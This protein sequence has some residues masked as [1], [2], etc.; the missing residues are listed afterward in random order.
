MS[1]VNLF[2]QKPEYFIIQSEMI[3]KHCKSRRINFTSCNTI[4]ETQVK[5]KELVCR[6]Q[7][8]GELKKL[9][10]GNIGSLQKLDIPGVLG[11]ISNLEI[12][13]PAGFKA[14][15]AETDTTFLQTNY[16]KWVEKLQE[17]IM[18]DIYITGAQAVTLKGEIFSSDNVGNQICGIIFGPRK[19]IIIVGKNSIYENL[20]T[21]LKKNRSLS[22]VIVYGAMEG[23]KDR[24]HLILVNEELKPMDDLI[25]A[26]NNSG[27]LCR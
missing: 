11:K 9:G 25:K 12:I 19:V 4:K 23:Y 14:N 1:N 18:S 15:I 24:I 26:D 6:S 7:N 21:A 3:A 20:D 2:G 5:I 8:N 10:L 17:S 16:D 27:E 13:N 22:S